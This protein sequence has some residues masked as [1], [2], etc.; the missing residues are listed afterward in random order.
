MSWH[1]EIRARADAPREAEVMIYGDIG[2][3]WFEETVTARE[4]VRDLAAVDAD[5]LTVRINSHGGSVVDGLA[6][7]NA[8]RRH[9][10]TVTTRVEGVA[11][12]IAS[13]IAMAGDERLIAEN[14]LYMMHG[15]WTVA[16]GPSKK[17]REAADLLDLHTASMVSAYASASGKPVEDIRALLSD[18]EDHWMS[19]D[20][21]LAEG[22]FTAITEGVEAVAALAPGARINYAP[23]QLQRPLAHSNPVQKGNP[24]SVPET[25][26][27]N[28][29]AAPDAESIRAQALKD[30]AA[31][32]TEIRALCARFKDYD[33]VPALTDALLDDPA[34]TIDTARARLLDHIGQRSEPIAGTSVV[35]LEDETDKRREAMAAAIMIRAG[36]A[37]R[38]TRAKHQGNPWRGHTLM[39]IARASLSR[40]GIR[41]DGLDRMTIAGMA[42][43][44]GTSD[45]QILLENVLHKT[46]QNAYATAP[47]T[48]SRFCVTGSV[49]DFR[50][51]K[52]YRVGSIG[53]L[54]TV[55]ELG[56]FKTKTIPD[57]ESDTVAIGT[58]GNIINISRQTIINDDL[59]AFTSLAVGAGR[60]AKRTIE[61]AVYAMLAENSGNGPLLEDGN[62]LFHAS[63]NN[64]VASG[65]APSVEQFDAMRVLMAAQKDV[66]GNDYLDLV[67]AIWLGP[68]GL[69]GTARVVNDS[70]YDPDASNKLQRANKVRGLVRDIVD[71]ARLTGTA[72]YMF[73]DPMDAPVFEVAFLD[74]NSEPY[75]ESQNGF[76]VDGTAWK[77]RLDF[78]VA[79]RDYRGA[80]KNNG[81]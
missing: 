33:G 27:D 44:Q 1:Y 55:T 42:F 78:G 75:L 72:Y 64:L 8:I 51:H 25:V 50:P 12:S 17:L 53:N 57:G 43:T 39:D 34:V 32:R 73:A 13:Y 48:W 52:R 49:S 3:S 80:V 15:A 6:I 7:Y 67:P 69:G 46:L 41:T 63:H 54:D 76:T 5:H 71:T 31:R 40:A 26:T 24:M 11:A 20:E 81:A 77:V 14:A 19:A 10:A 79:P 18:G 2:E 4:F 74:G 65:A 29:P 56:E 37:D 28:T 45:F 61:A 59:G 30:E 70:E 66:G 62:P 9:P 22:Y 21:A 68:K 36:V 60:A 16:A 58:R 38:E 35:T 23:R 47:D